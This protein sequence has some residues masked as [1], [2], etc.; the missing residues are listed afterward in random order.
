MIDSLLN[1]FTCP[2]RRMTFPLTVR[3]ESG[4]NL[5]R[6]TYVV[7]LT[8]GKQFPYNWQELRIERPPRAP[9]AHAFSRQI[10]SNLFS[11]AARFAVTCGV[12]S[13]ER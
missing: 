11:K 6:K 1:L 8:C 12:R 10:F 5:A 4:P 9:R 13:Y 3:E 2:H 7:C